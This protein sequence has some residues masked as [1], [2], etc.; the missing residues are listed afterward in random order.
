M[1]CLLLE[2]L[3]QKNP[4]QEV[5]IVENVPVADEDPF[6][7]EINLKVRRLRMEEWKFDPVC[8]RLFFSTFRV[9]AKEGTFKAFELAKCEVSEGCSCEEG[10]REWV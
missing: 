10:L 6:L 1:L 3:A 7:P 9:A 8:D 5:T 2:S 4:G